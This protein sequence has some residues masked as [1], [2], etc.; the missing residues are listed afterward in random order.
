[1]RRTLTKPLN[2]VCFLARHVVPRLPARR[3][4]DTHDPK[5]TLGV[6]LAAL[7]NADPQSRI[8]SPI[9]GCVAS[10]QRDPRRPANELGYSSY[11]AADINCDAV[12]IG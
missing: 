2:P 8:R 6:A 5:R 1:M 12:G 10:Q 9:C 7:C 11:G 3:A 4:S